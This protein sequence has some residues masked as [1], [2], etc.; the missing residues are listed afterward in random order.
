MTPTA[1][2][3]TILGVAVV[4]G[5]AFFGALRYWFDQ[6]HGGQKH[7]SPSEKNQAAQG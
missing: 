6:K 1:L 3:W 5:G 7:P 4:G 2:L